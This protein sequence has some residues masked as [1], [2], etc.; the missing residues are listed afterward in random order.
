MV[1]LFVSVRVSAPIF[2]YLVI[3]QVDHLLRKGSLCAVNLLQPLHREGV[4]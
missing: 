2:F 4:E 1:G 3:F